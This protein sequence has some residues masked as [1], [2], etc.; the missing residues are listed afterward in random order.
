MGPGTRISDPYV[1]VVSWAP[2]SGSNPRTPGAKKVE[3]EGPLSPMAGSGGTHSKQD[4]QDE[5]LASSQGSVTVKTGSSRSFE[6]CIPE[7]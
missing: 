2:L 6:S 7:N 5:T 1:Y 4:V 3:S